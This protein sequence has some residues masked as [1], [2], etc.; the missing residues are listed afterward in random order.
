MLGLRRFFTTI[1]GFKVLKGV[2]GKLCQNFEF[3]QCSALPPNWGN[4]VLR[5]FLRPEVLIPLFPFKY[6]KFGASGWHTSRCSTGRRNYFE[7]FL[8]FLNSYRPNAGLLKIS[9]FFNMCRCGRCGVMYSLNRPTTLSPFLSWPY[10]GLRVLAEC[11]FFGGW[12]FAR[13]SL[14]L[15]NQ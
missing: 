2:W 13:L 7:K 9:T 15:I 5:W 11:L 14:L 8:L 3:R 4:F 1:G 10:N 6:Q 12:F